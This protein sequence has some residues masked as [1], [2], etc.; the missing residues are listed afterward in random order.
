MF[1]YLA[2]RDLMM[3]SQLNDSAFISNQAS[4]TRRFATP[5]IKLSPAFI[6]QWFLITIFY[7]GR[8]ISQFP[9]S[10]VVD[11]KTRRV[12]RLLGLSFVR[13]VPLA[14]QNPYPIIFSLFQPILDLIFLSYHF[15][16]LL[17]VFIP[18]PSKSK[19]KTVNRRRLI[20][21][22][23][24]KDYKINKISKSQVWTTYCS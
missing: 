5:A 22:N 23:V 10:V 18:T 19:F 14:C 2:L 24:I 12:Q 6:K 7:F 15:W 17:L 8:G 11:V 21:T 3:F 4:W 9:I 13:Y 16:L 20:I 1:Q